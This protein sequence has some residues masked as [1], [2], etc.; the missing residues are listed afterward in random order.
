MLGFPRQARQIK[1][2]LRFHHAGR[3]PVY[4]TS[5]VFSASADPATNRD[6]D[7]VRF[8][9]IPW[10]L[11]REGQWAEERA[12]LQAIWPRRSQRYQR[13]FAL[14]FDAYQVVPWL[15]TLNI[16]GFAYFPGATG[17]LTLD[18]N[19]QLHRAL[20]WAQLHKGTAHKILSR[21]GQ[22]EPEG[23]WRPR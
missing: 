6:M 4:S 3:V 9:D 22:D 17:V 19:K 2:Q 7:G 13:L 14:G 16:P 11:D 18:Q 21:E 10:V 23:N 1:P 15:D 12:K 8:C 20:E 5:H